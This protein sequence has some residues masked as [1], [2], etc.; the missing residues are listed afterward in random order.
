MNKY[1]EQL[2]KDMFIESEDLHSAYLFYTLTTD[3]L[4]TTLKQVVEMLQTKQ[5]HEDILTYIKSMLKR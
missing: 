4:S 2:S 3:K 1:F 5:S